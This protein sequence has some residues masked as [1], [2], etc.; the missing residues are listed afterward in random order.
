MLK[1]GFTRHDRKR[2]YFRS[3]RSAAAAAVT[4]S[5]L[6]IRREIRSRE[7]PYLFQSATAL[8]G[9]EQR[10]VIRLCD[11]GFLCQLWRS[12]LAYCPG[13]CFGRFFAEKARICQGWDGG[14][15]RVAGS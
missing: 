11:F 8:I 7:E 2:H 10:F 4:V 1:G 14:S 6:R 3:A 5:S 9:I 15:I 12:Q 13:C